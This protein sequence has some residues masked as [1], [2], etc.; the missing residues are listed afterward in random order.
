MTYTQIHSLVKVL[1]SESNIT[2]DALVEYI[3]ELSGDVVFVWMSNDVD[4]IIRKTTSGFT[5]ALNSTKQSTPNRLAHALGH[6]IIHMHFLDKTQWAKEIEYI[7]SSY[8]RNRYSTEE[9]EAA[10]F[11]E[12]LLK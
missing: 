2:S 6:V 1:K 8:H 10:I 7:D 4:S 3:N 9:G 5:I 12:L 11:A